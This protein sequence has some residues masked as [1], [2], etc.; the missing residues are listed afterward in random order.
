MYSVLQ[1][2]FVLR[3]K[4]P[5]WRVLCCPSKLIMHACRRSLND[6]CCVVVTQKSA[7]RVSQKILSWCVKVATESAVQSPLLLSKICA[8]RPESPFPC[9]YLFIYMAAHSL[10]GCVRIPKIPYSQHV[11]IFFLLEVGIFYGGLSLIEY[12]TSFLNAFEYGKCIYAWLTWR[13]P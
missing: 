1:K 11:E 2:S 12:S 13:F 6:A 8:C 4:D 7:V 3:W 10:Y 9:S 5:E